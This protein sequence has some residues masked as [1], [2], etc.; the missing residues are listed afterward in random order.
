MNKL[1]PNPEP[2][3][4]TPKIV[5]SADIGGSE[6]KAIAQIYPSGVPI[7]LAMPP[8]IADVSKTS[9][10]RFVPNSYNTSVWVGMGDE[11]YVLGALAKSVFAGTSALRDL[12]SH[13]ALPKLAAL[14][15]LACRQ[16][17]FDTNN[18]DAFV[19]VLMPPGEISNAHNLGK[20]L[21]QSLNRGIVTPTN[22]LKGKLRNFHVAPEGSGIMIY[23]SRTLAGSYTQKNIGLL[24]LGYRNASFVLSQKGNPALAETT[25]LGMNWLVQQFVQRTAVGLS[26]EDEHLVTAIIA[27]GK[28]NFAP[29]RSLSRQATPEGV[30]ADLKLFQNILPEVRSDYCRAL[31]RS[32][33]NIPS[34]D[35]ILICG[36]TADFVKK[37]LTDHFQNE[38]IPIVWNGGVQFPA[39]LNTLGLGER[40]ADVWTAHITY[41]LMLDKNFAYDRKQDLVPDPNKPRPSTPT[42]GLAQLREYAKKREAE[43]PLNS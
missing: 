12:K 15:W 41:I 18:I 28:G 4:N 27:A 33:R 20:K 8:E 17:Q 40:V 10:G 43:Q 21:G 24:M 23:R 32:L 36:G 35:E 1:N 13:Y 42:S 11:Y 5:I 16:F 14:L 39:P 37:E 19:Q 26:K 9:V 7:V 30:A 22:K 2:T 6:T 25:D 29:L 38:G 31:V 3:V 34:L